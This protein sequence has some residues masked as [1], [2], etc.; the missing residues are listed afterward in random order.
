VRRRVALALA[1]LTAWVA[2]AAV[3]TTPSPHAQ[4]APLLLERAHKAEFLPSF[5]GKKPIFILAL[6]SD[7]RPGQNI[8]AER[9]DSIHIIGV[10]PLKHTASILG[11]PRD[12]FVPIP[13]H[14]SGKITSAM[15]LGGPP[16]TIKTIEA[17]TG[18]HVDFFLITSFRGLRNMVDA[19]GGLT[20]NVT[21][22]MHDHFSHA[23]FD[24]GEHHFTG[25]QALA[26]ARDRH[27]FTTGDLARSGNQGQLFLSALAG[28]RKQ[29]AKDP[30]S[31]LT[32]MGAGLRNV[33]TDLSIPELLKLAFTAREVLPGATKNVVVP[34]H[35]GT[36]GDQSVV[37]IDAG[38]KALYDDMRNDGVLNGDAA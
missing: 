2:G 6:G 20:V 5:T 23:D 12:S 15:E 29:F 26:F 27:D 11:F 37:F 33:Q 4:A 7:A 35:G 9:S 10:N 32:W 25:A 28:F 24:P 38:A 8:L 30:G 31:V 34:A 21:Q 14:G 22:P 18:I 3:G 19:V 36:V 17:L 1:A 16:L 13:G